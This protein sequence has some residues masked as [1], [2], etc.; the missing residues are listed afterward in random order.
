MLSPSRV[1]LWSLALLL[2]THSA[3]AAPL[4][5]QI[6]GNWTSNFGPV[7][8][9]TLASHQP[10]I[11]T[12]KGS[13]QEG[14]GKKGLINSGRFTTSN[15]K[16]ALNFTETWSH[17]SGTAVLLLDKSG[18]SFKGKFK[19]NNGQTGEWIWKR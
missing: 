13:W 5:P 2:A 14:P 1:A 17:N 7:H 16:L 12:I 18:K 8:V 10:G 9:D 6:A 19:L 3:L 11:V 15:N 4:P